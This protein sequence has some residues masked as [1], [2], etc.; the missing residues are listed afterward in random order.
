MA[1]GKDRKVSPIG[2][3]LLAWGVFLTAS[4]LFCWGAWAFVQATTPTGV[5]LFRP[6]AQATLNLRL[7]GPAGTTP[8]QTLPPAGIARARGFVSRFSL[9]PLLRI[10]VRTPTV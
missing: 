5:G 9:L 8:P 3:A 1:S 2:R 4:V 10:H 6:N 7:G